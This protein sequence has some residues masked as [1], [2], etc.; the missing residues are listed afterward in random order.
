[1]TDTRDERHFDCIAWITLIIG[2]SWFLLVPGLMLINFNFPSD[3]WT[4]Y[5]VQ[6][7]GG[8]IVGMNV[9]GKPSPRRAC[10]L[11]VSINGQPCQVDPLPSVPAHLQLGQVVHYTVQRN[12]QTLSIDVTMVR[13]DALALWR[14]FVQRWQNELSS[15]LTAFIS[16]LVTAFAFAARPRNRAAQ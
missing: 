4:D 3:G 8:Y 7:N 5:K 6:P 15:L 1:T 13:R 14:G 16:F 11:V 2:L 10:D 12:G 9:T